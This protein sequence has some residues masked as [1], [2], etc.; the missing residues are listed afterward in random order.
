MLES[1]P[2]EGGVGPLYPKPSLQEIRKRFRKRNV[3]FGQNAEFNAEFD[4]Y[5]R[6]NYLSESGLTIFLAGGI[7]GGILVSLN[8]FINK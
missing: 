1:T 3:L 6:A 2:E 7:A 5:I 8:R 4:T